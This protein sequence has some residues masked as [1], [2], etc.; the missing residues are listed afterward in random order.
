ML[1]SFVTDSTVHTREML[2]PFDRLDT[3]V[4]VVD[5]DPAGQWWANLASLPLF[6]AAT[7]EALIARSKLTTPSPASRTRMD[8][9]R[10]TFERGERSID[11]WTFYPEGGAPFA[12]ECHSAGI[13]ITDGPGQP[14]RLAMLVEARVLG[15]GA[16]NPHERRGVEAL[17]Y[18]GELVSL[19]GESGEALMRNPAAVRALGDPAPGDQLAAMLVDPHQ[20]VA[21][22]AALAREPTVR[23][24]L[25]LR[26]AT[27][28]RWYDSEL[29]RSVDP[30]TGAPAILVTQRDITDRRADQAALED[31][32]ARLAAH[33]EALRR[34][35]A[36]VIQVGADVL[37]L[38]LI[39]DLDHARVEAALAAL[40]ARIAAGRIARVV[41]DLTGV[42]AFDEVGA[43]GV[44]RIVRALRLQGV[45]TALSGIHP[46]LAQAIVGLGVD[47]GGIACHAALVDALIAPRDR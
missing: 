12:A 30:V 27:G 35:A 32:R 4:W 25:L 47:L 11:T 46:T 21:V 42:A 44:L 41:L 7:R 16:V 43:A 39:G 28:E 33:A 36:P 2:A 20:A 37:A 22:R 10:R 23:L 29:R 19:H 34:L 26:T 13:H 38:P 40:H 9:L 3:P 1:A 15:P 6:A 45:E 8:V 14:A 24:D 5:F 17:R 31:Q 18:L